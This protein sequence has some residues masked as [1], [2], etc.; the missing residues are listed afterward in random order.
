MKIAVIGAKDLTVKPEVIDRY[1]QELYPK[2]AARGHQ[3]DLFVQPSYHQPCFSINYYHQIRVIALLSIPG[4]Q[5]NFL[6]NSALNTIWATLGNYDVIHIHGMASA[7]FSWFP[8]LFSGSSIVV[9][10]HQL[11]CRQTKW[12]RLWRGLLPHMEKIAVRNANEI[13][14]TSKALTNYFRQRYDIYPQY[15]ANAPA[16]YDL[17]LNHRDSC[18]RSL[19]LHNQKY[20]LYWGQIEPDHRIDLLIRA[21]QKLQLYNWRL[22]ITGA[23]DIDP[24]YASNLLSIAKLQGNQDNIII[25]GDIRGNALAEL[26]RSS[27]IF[28]DPSTGIDLNLSMTMLE[29]MRQGIPILASD[30]IAHRQLLNDNRGLLFKSGQLDS[31]VRQLEYAIEQPDLLQAMAKKAQ[32]Y[33]AVNHNW[34]KVTYQNLFLYMQLS[35]TNYAAHQGTQQSGEA[36]QG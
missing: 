33:I 18:N 35:V 3:V 23:I 5:L 20:L 6:L 30:T 1:C 14:V 4:K 16:S 7:W 27:S 19:G 22:V 2:I 17:P 9:T 13:I 25:L 21:F 26:I 11:D 29:V 12:R 8:Q 24:G 10:C 36:R 32:H 28:V 31:L 34:D 15:I